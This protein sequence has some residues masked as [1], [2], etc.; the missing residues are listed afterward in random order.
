[1]NPENKAMFEINSKVVCVDDRFPSAFIRSHFPALPRKGMIYTVRD[2]VPGQ[3]NNL[4][5]TVAVLLH[6]IVSPPNP[7]GIEPGFAPWRF[8]TMDDVCQVKEA[9]EQLSIGT[10]SAAQST[11]TPFL[12]PPASAVGPS[13]RQ[14][15]FPQFPGR[16]T[17]TTPAVAG[18]ENSS[19]KFSTA[20][21]QPSC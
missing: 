19:K 1:M 21:R 11:T 3:E 9:V 8:A 12:R 20:H 13:H 15:C 10:F 2:I 4:K 14:R 18:I 5:P 17:P 7:H 16:L 6:E